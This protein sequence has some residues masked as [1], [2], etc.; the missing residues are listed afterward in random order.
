MVG[1]GVL[2]QLGSERLLELIEVRAVGGGGQGVQYRQRPLQ[3]LT[4]SLQ[5]VDGI[6]DRGFGL[7]GGDRLPL[8]ALGG[9]PGTDG[10]FDV[11]VVHSREAGQAKVE[12]PWLGEDVRLREVGAVGGLAHGPIVPCTDGLLVHNRPSILGL[13]SHWA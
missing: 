8:L 6:G 1:V 12:R 10:R 2:R 11:G 3:Q 5:G 9:H 7:I 13:W 4:G